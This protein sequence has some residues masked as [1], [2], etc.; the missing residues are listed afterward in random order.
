MEVCRQGVSAEL[1]E[2]RL[3]PTSDAGLGGPRR[4]AWAISAA[5]H[6]LAVAVMMTAPP[7]RT[8]LFRAPSILLERPATLVAPPPELK[9]LTQ[10]A[11]NTGKVGREFDL[12]SLLP[13]PPL[14]LPPG[15]FRLPP[16]R[17]P[18]ESASAVLPEPPEL[19]GTAL[20]QQAPPLPIPSPQ[21]E[22]VERP[23]LAFESPRAVAAAA[24]TRP[25]QIP[26]P[27]PSVSE[28]AQA[29]LRSRGRGGLIVGD[30]ELGGAGVAEMLNLPPA[31]GRQGSALELL[32]D[33][34]GVDFRPYLIQILATVRRNWYAV[35]PEVA[36]LGRQGK[37]VIQFAINRDG[38]VPKLVIVSPSG[39]EALDRAAVAGIS[40][41]NPFPPL[42]SDYRGLQIRLQFTFL[43]NMPRQ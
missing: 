42:P 8:T 40:A 14:R 24:A 33:P 17:D 27:A 20:L 34:M 25:G 43:Y 38:S 31:P 19:A 41:S 36:R 1:A 12:E 35:I 9:E 37:V 21:I 7:T 28:A 10:R 2:L 18:K 30:V 13:R 16:P 29:A 22:P 4:Q 3:L 5:L 6:A 11:P 15:G 23:K 32:S 26:P 39:T